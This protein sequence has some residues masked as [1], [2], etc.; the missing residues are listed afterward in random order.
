MTVSSQA[1]ADQTVVV[2][3]A[4]AGI[5]LETARQAR[6]AGARLV[7]TGRNP[8]RLAQ[9]AA[10]LDPVQT[11][12]F[13][14]NDTDR[15]RQFF[16]DLP[17]PIDHVLVTAGGPAYMPLDGMDLA[18]ARQAMDERMAVT[19]GVALFSRDKVRPRGGLLFIGGTGGRRPAVGMAVVATLTAALPALIRNLA[20]ELAPIRANV[21]APGFV[22]T[23][24]SARL[25][26]DQIEARRAELRASLPIRRVVGPAD[27]AA[28]AIHLMCNE[29]L[30]GAT[31]D[32]DGGQ[33]LVS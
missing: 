13:D 14:V 22:D 30:T 19:L 5:G 23:P 1:L 26:G 33:Q 4:S 28:L 11:A 3:G 2:L 25:L 21:I 12:A 27:V 7:L 20:L 9:A 10:E 15:L 16:A 29:A 31:F 6:A 18:A 17:A 32:V 8:D 24:L